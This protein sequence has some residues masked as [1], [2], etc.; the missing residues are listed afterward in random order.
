M[1]GAVCGDVYS[2]AMFEAYKTVELV[3]GVIRIRG[4]T[5]RS[6]DCRI[7]A[8]PTTYAVCKAPIFSGNRITRAGNVT[9][10]GGVMLMFAPSLIMTGKGCA[11][12]DRMSIQ[13]N[14]LSSRPCDRHGDPTER[15]IAAGRHR[16]KPVMAIVGTFARRIPVSLMPDVKAQASHVPYPSTSSWIRPWSRRRLPRNDVA[17]RPAR[18]APDDRRGVADRPALHGQNE[19]SAHVPGRRSFGTPFGWF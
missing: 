19:Q 4:K 17:G 11:L 16:L 1:T 7:Q 13:T 18:T 15:R 12:P 5:W 6:L 14:M 9:K 10:L 2:T 3:A 8:F